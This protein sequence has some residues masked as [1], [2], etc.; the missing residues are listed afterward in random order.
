VVLV[1]VSYTPPMV[2]VVSVAEP[3]LALVVC[4]TFTD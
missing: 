3:L 1:K 4:R 2:R